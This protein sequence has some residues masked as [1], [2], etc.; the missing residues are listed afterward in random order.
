MRRRIGIIIVILLIGT[1]LALARPVREAAPAIFE[2]LEARGDAGRLLFVL[3][4]F[5]A[6]FLALPVAWITVGGGALFGPWIAFVLATGGANAAANVAF[7]AGRRLGRARF[8]HWILQYPKLAAVERAVARDGFRLILLARLSPISPYGILNY[9]LSV[10]PVAQTRFA[11]ATLIGKTPGTLFYC[12]LG[13]GARGA[14]EAAAGNVEKPQSYYWL[15][16][17]G[18]ASTGAL[19]ALITKVARKALAEE[20]GGGHSTPAPPP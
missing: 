9:T 11:L 8:Q 19:I 6:A 16:A 1:A 3:F 13:A 10:M 7:F 5:P 12:F 15:L 18:I 20:I 2:W 14:A 4:Y 17:A